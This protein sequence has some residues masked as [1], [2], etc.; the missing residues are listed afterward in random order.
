MNF[1]QMALTRQ[2]TR[3]YDASKEVEIE[4]LVRI[5][6]LGMLAPSACNSQPWK[7]HILNKES[8][9]LDALRKS[10]QVVGLNKFLN[11]VNSF[12]VIEQVFGNT[13]AKLGSTM[14]KNDLNSMDIGIL[15]S[16]L[17]FAAMEE[18][19]GTCILGAFRKDVM[20]KAMG[21]S[22]SQIVRLVIAVGYPRENDPIRK[23]VRKTSEKVIE[24]H[25]N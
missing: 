18:G 14:G 7:L 23:K 17:C 8:S 16:Y 1:E 4:K 12:I 3:N 15:A 25:K 10:C 19:L 6:E 9:N 2:S 5:C 13:S 22:K 21:F 11:D 20:Q 24:I